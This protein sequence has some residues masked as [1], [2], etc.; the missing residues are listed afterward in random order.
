VLESR[1]INGTH[2]FDLSTALQLARTAE[3][4]YAEPG[5]VEQTVLTAW[6]WSHFCFLD[7]EATQ[8][9][10]AADA[11][12]IIVCFRGTEGNSLGDWI[13]DLDFDLVD[14]PLGG[15]VHE[16]FYDA[17]SCVWHLLDKDV[18]RLQNDRP[19]RLWV[20]GHSLGASLAALAVARWC[21]AD[22]EVA[23]LYAFG[24]PRT[25]DTT[26]AR[27]FDF[28]F[29][30]HAFRIVN[31]HD[32]VTRTPPRSLGYQ[33]LGTFVYFTGSGDLSHDVSWW[34]GFVDGWQGAIETILDWGRPGIEDHRM[35]N[36]R[37]RIEDAYKSQAKKPA[38]SDVLPFSRE[39]AASIPGLTKPRRR[40]A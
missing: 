7:I 2:H 27:N 6:K 5:I 15:R 29:R 21:E 8:C 37:Q 24:Q 36:Y 23:G 33:H 19:R 10:V 18:C 26:F 1:L 28:A 20:T 30:P 34:Q 39:E 9:F 11:Q 4:A 17:L 25:G 31:N 14:G 3:L 12:S 38:P 32:I 13:T 35:S 22:C 40:A 16:G